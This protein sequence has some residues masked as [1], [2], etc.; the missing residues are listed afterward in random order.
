MEELFYTIEEK[1]IVAWNEACYGESAKAKIMA[2]QILDEDPG[3]A[4][5]HYLLGHLYYYELADF[6][7]AKAHFEMAIGFEPALP[8]TYEVYLKMLVHLKR[9]KEALQLAAKALDVP[10]VCPACINKHIGHLYEKT[11]EFK[12]AIQYYRE[13]KHACSNCCDEDALN[14][15]LQRTERKL[16]STRAFQYTT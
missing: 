14:N 16:R 12:L 10:G 8:W 15:S 2:E 1:Y 13:A 11:G 5:A 9:S 6:V 3:Y 4:R 7:K